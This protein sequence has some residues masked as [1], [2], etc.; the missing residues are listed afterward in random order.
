MSAGHAGVLDRGERRNLYSERPEASER[1]EAQ[2]AAYLEAA[3][4]PWGAEPDQTDLNDLQLN[5]LRA[6]G[7]VI[8]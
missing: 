4:S 6:L 5:Q 3:K 2:A 1:L 7:Y 8:K